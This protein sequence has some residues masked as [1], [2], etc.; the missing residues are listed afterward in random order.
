MKPSAPRT[1]G[2]FLACYTKQAQRAWRH[3]EGRPDIYFEAKLTPTTSASS[4]AGSLKSSRT[5]SRPITSSR[6]RLRA[7]LREPDG[8]LPRAV[9]VWRDMAEIY[10]RKYMTH[11]ELSRYEVPATAGF[12]KFLH[13]I[14]SE[15]L[16]KE[17]TT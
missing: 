2:Q 10:G 15:A 16:G 12:I 17:A 7:R 8:L 4:S 11:A 1:A 6:H 14:E 13:G 3:P 5:I 9:A